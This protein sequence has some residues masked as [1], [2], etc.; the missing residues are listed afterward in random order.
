MWS[1]GAASG[2]LTSPLD[3]GSVAGMTG[4]LGTPSPSPIK[5]EGILAEAGG[6]DVLGVAFDEGGNVVEGHLDAGE[7]GLGGVGGDVG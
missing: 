1:R 3:S 5:G 2:P 4:R 7:G 6:E